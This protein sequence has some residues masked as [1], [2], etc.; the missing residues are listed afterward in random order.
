MWV[1]SALIMTIDI[2]TR[3]GYGQ[4]AFTKRNTY[5]QLIAHYY[6]PLQI[7]IEALVTRSPKKM[8][9]FQDS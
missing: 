4:R 8:R 3:T 7:V 5:D 9:H 6:K 1:Q 2:L